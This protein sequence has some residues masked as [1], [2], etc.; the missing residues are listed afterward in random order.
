MAQFTHPA[1]AF[2]PFEPSDNQIAVWRFVAQETGNAFVRAVAGAGKSTTI[3]LAI[4]FAPDWV[5]NICFLAFNKKIAEELKRKIEELIR[6]LLDVRE[7]SQGDHSTAEIDRIINRLRRCRV[8]T[9]HS[10]G[11]GAYRF[12]RKSARIDGDKVRGLL[13]IAKPEGGFTETEVKL[14]GSLACRLVSIAK[15]LG[16]GVLSEGHDGQWLGIVDHHGFDLDS[17]EGTMGECVDVAKR[18]LRMSN[19]VSMRAVDPVIDFDDM[20]YMPILAGS[21]FYPQDLV[22]VDEEQDSNPIQLEMFK[23]M[24]R[25]SGANRGRIIGVG[26]PRQAIY[27]FRGS[28]AA[29]VDKFIAM[30]H[31]TELPLTVSY[32]CGRAI[33]ESAKHLCPEMEAAPNAHEGEVLTI[34]ERDCKFGP[35]DAII[36]RVNAPLVQKAMR[37]IADRQPCRMLGR[38]I[39]Q[40]L[41]RLIKKMRATDMDDLL[42]KIDVWEKKERERWLKKGKDSQAEAVTDRADCIRAFI[43]EDLEQSLPNLLRE[44]E[45]LFTD[46][47][48]ATVLT[49]ASAHK[50]KG[51]ERPRIFILKPEM[52]QLKTRREWTQE[53]ERNVE[54]VM[55][56]RAINSLFMVQS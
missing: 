17:D 56:T 21:S 2:I 8:S 3:L 53:Q 11:L 12:A 24:L 40:G 19:E 46:D 47:P 6:K 23:R 41:V 34:K 15:G 13:D 43:G 45:D 55:R 36:C 32:R 44:V 33:V 29:A 42:T 18:L 30:F 37:L 27:G 31:A 38:D 51:S 28:D 52:M 25:K 14:Y 9:C 39:G 54:Y 4:M 20:L 49:L 10:A 7:G 26:D 22:F 48:N 5:Q 1:L 16:F 35:T 50:F